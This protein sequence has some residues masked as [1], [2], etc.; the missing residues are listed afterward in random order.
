[1]FLIFQTDL[2]SN[3]VLQLLVKSGFIVKDKW[4][5]LIGDLGVSSEE[6][7]RLKKIASSDQDYHSAL[8]EGLQ[9]WITNSTD[10]SWEKLISALENCG[11]KDVATTLKRQVDSTKDEGIDYV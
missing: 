5:G 6:V 8:E 1:M 4:I 11:D 3:N 7:I 10:P 2:T 9:S